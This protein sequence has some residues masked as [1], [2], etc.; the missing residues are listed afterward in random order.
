MSAR[1]SL[2]LLAFMVPALAGAKQTCEVVSVHDGDTFTA[3][4]NDKSVRIR[5]SSIDAPELDQTWGPA[6]RNFAAELLREGHV[7]LE[8]I[9][10]DRYGRTVAKVQMSDG[11]DL[12]REMV[13]AGFA[14]HYLAYSLDPELGKLETEAKAA[15]RGIW[16]FG[17]SERP[18]EFRATKR[19]K[20]KRSQ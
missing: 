18:S 11:R 13:R 19:S 1:L 6:S 10:R 3:L 12:A 5:V 4:C 7:E 14:F 9:D 2:I 17:G 15:N 16:S 8:R 20:V